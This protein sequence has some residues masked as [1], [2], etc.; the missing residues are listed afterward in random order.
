MRSSLLLSGTGRD[1]AFD[2]DRDEVV[3]PYQVHEDGNGPPLPLR[4][5]REEA[6][7]EVPAPAA[8][9]PLLEPV[10]GEGEAILHLRKGEVAA[11]GQQVAQGGPACTV[12]I[13]SRLAPELHDGWWDWWF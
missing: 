10:P 8:M 7:G 12:E 5:D 3:Q 6:T 13:R 4:P 11:E 9:G 1:R 2:L